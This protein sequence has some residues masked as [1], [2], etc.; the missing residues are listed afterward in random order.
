VKTMI[1]RRMTIGLE[2][3]RMMKIRGGWLGRIKA[4][5]RLSCESFASC[6][7]PRWE[8]KTGHLISPSPSS[9]IRRRTQVVDHPLEGYGLLSQR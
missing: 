2:K 1:Y 7:R 9:P 5:S 6:T 8:H 4:R 3:G